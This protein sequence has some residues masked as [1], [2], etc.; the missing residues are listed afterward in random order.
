MNLFVA[1]VK[2]IARSLTH[3]ALHLILQIHS[4]NS[5]LTNALFTTLLNLKNIKLIFVFEITPFN[6]YFFVDELIALW[7]RDR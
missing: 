4:T 1:H 2:D 3:V 5:M 7:G 6:R